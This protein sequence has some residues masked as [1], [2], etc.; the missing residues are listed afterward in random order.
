[1]DPDQLVRR[2]KQIGLDGVC[3]TE[4]D[5]IWDKEAIDRLKIKHDFLVIGGVEVSTDYGEILAFGLH[6]S[7]LNISKA[8]DLR[9]A[10]DEVDG[11]MILAHPFRYEPD[12]V[13]GY[14][15]SSSNGN[16]RRQKIES[17]CRDPVFKLVDAVE[18]YNGRSGFDEVEFAHL[19]TERLS[20]KAT[21][22]SD[23]HASLEVGSC[24]SV[25]K[26][27]VKNEKDF[28][29]QIKRGR[30][31]GVDGRWSSLFSEIKS[32]GRH[33]TFK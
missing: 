19:V 2:A 17:V 7:V 30:F 16:C 32:R 4:H 27:R 23:S 21:G 6:Q 25:F 1:M 10:V 9:K 29:A 11:V 12:L 3:I 28:I 31:Q 24:Y 33:E 26:D 20:L 14:F 8:K 13:S 15:A 18:V 22:G 5:Q